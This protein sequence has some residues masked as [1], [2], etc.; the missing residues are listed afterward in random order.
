M[1]MMA[2][3][4]TSPRSE[5]L[6]GTLKELLPAVLRPYIDPDVH[7]LV[8]VTDVIVSGDLSIAQVFLAQVGETESALDELEKNKKRI[9]HALAKVVKTRRTLELRFTTDATPEQM[10]SLGNMM[11]QTDIP[12]TDA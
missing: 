12:K 7:G 10:I 11:I 2:L 8:T 9:S 1:I 4:R 6:S 3:M 5:K